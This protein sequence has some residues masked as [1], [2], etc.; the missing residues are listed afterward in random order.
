MIYVVAVVIVV[1]L[2]LLGY[3]LTKNEKKLPGVPGYGD[4]DLPKMG[5]E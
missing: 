4:D 1:I 5:K 3:V 2:A